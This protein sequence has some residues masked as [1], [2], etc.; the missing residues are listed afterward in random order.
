MDPSIDIGHIVLFLHLRENFDLD[1]GLD[2]LSLDD[3]EYALVAL[4]L[5]GENL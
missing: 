1:S 2:L 3:A 4:H 5:R